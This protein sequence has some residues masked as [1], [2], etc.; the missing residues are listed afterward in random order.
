MREEGGRVVDCCG[1]GV[2][3]LEGGVAEGGGVHFEVLRWWVGV[4]WCL[5]GGV[6]LC[7]VVLCLLGG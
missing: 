4:W 2:G 5:D 3:L 6:A 7:C 1:V